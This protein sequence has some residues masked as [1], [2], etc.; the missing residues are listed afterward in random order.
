MQIETSVIRVQLVKVFP[1]HGSLGAQYDT[2]EGRAL[3]ERFRREVWAK[4]QGRPIALGTVK[5]ARGWNCDTDFVWRVVE[6]EFVEDC[7]GHTFGLCRH[8]FE[9]GD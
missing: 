5:S 7:G 2:P 9:A 8:M 4:W 6:P 3:V 1:V